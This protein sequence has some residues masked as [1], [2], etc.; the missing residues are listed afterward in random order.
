MVPNQIFGRVFRLKYGEDTG[1]LYS[2]VQGEREYLI[3]AKHCIAGI[4]DEDTIEVMR[5]NQWHRFPVKI[6]GHSVADVSVL[7]T[8]RPLTTTSAFAPFTSQDLI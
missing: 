6:C 5:D 8:D 3:T 2:I 1:T 4:A 7:A